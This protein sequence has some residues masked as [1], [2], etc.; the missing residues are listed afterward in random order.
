MIKPFVRDKDAPQACLMLAEAACYYKAQGK[1]LVDVLYG[2]YDELGYY[3]ESQTSLTLTGQ[4]GA[5]R[6]KQILSDLR[7]SDV[8]EINGMKVVRFED[9]KE[10]VIKENGTVSELS[11]FTKSDVLKY[12]L[13][14]GSWIAIR[15][16][17]TE[18]KCKFYFCIKGTSLQDAHEKTV[19]YQKAIAEMTK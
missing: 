3:E 7:N 19:A 6:I 13:A 15:P 11:G 1:T 5:M 14:D 4:E 17:G 12:Y 2:L 10:C 8:T 18:P 9:Y 16:S